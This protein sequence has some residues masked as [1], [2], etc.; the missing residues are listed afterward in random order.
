[1]NA[2]VS[3]AHT[4]S[5]PRFGEALVT[6]GAITVSVVEEAVKEASRLDLRV[7]E[8][9]V[10]EGLITQADALHA[11]SLQGQ[12]LRVS[13]VSEIPDWD[14][15]LSEPDAGFGSSSRPRD[16]VVIALRQDRVKR[17]FLLLAEDPDRTTRPRSAAIGVVQAAS[18]HGYVMAGTVRV[19]AEL[20]PILHGQIDNQKGSSPGAVED[21]PT[22]M[23][24]LFDEIG[25]QAY[26]ENASDIHM[27]LERGRGTISFRIHGDLE[28]R[29]DMK[30]EELIELCSTV[31]NTLP[32][33]GSTKESFNPRK[34]QDA[35]IER[36]F[37]EGLVRFRY[38]G[39]PLA[40]DGFDVT[41][42]VVPIGVRT[43]PKTMRQLGYSPDQEE[44]LERAFG[45][46]SGMILFM[47]TTG[48][49][50]STSLAHSLMKLAKDRPG[51]K[52]RTVE[53]PVE[54]K[55]EGAYQT[56]VTRIHGDRRDFTIVLRQLMRADP[57]ILMVGEI[58]DDDTADLG[59]QGVRSGHLLV[60]TLHADGAPI[61]FDRLAGM[62]VSRQDLA[63]VG[64]I[65]AFVY[66]RLV[67][68]LCNACKIPLSQIENS[69]D[70]ATQALIHRT[71]RALAGDT[72]GVHF[73]SPKGCPSC[74]GRG[75]TGRTVCAEVLMPRGKRMLDA[76]K[77]AD[78]TALWAEW[79][80]RIDQ[81]NPSCMRGRTAFEHA[82]WKMSQGVVSPVDVEKE[83][84]FLDEEPWRDL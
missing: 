37:R 1:M 44:D 23:Q 48:S 20:I 36:R 56:P 63:A 72:S 45:H 43:K 21:D 35:V 17:C 51:K 25:Y 11:A 52:I 64:L 31:Y 49:G 50:K 76:I 39:L 29:R 65:V 80:S 26:T 6:I 15:V 60:S 24:K 19:P 54:Y 84:K 67:P 18:A 81:E 47:G 28:E 82:I 57:D 12:E 33:K 13:K 8:Y 2:Q 27:T 74:E 16:F 69:S 53:E 14:F 58:R 55:I 3:R 42:R 66:Q 22:A 75:V 7:G 61:G 46:S 59:L 79:R 9:L 32:E 38:S 40:P 34:C 71:R 30:A 78:S 41:L 68:V 77:S 70:G 73:R 4:L 62:S 5:A 83:F 10:R